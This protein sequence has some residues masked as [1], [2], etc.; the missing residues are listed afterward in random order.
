MMAVKPEDLLPAIVSEDT[1]KRTFA[2]KKTP[3]AF[4]ESATRTKI[5]VKSGDTL[6]QLAEKHGVTL[7][8][9]M[10]ANASIKNPNMIR[11][12]QKINIP[13][14]R[15]AK[16]PVYKDWGRKNPQT[17]RTMGES[18]RAGINPYMRVRKNKGGLAREK[19]TSGKMATDPKTIAKSQ[20]SMATESMK[21]PPKTEQ[22]TATAKVS[23]PAVRGKNRIIRGPGPHNI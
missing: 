8:A 22:W 21:P 14:E 12:G 3:Q 20:H 19:F 4:H 7:D 13:T 16:G 18:V 2:E 5:V 1:G 9:V 15:T 23:K 10:K 17:G 11:V 6:S